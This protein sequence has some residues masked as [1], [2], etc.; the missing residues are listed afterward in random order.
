MLDRN[1]TAAGCF[2]QLN[3]VKAKE[4]WRK[5]SKEILTSVSAEILSRNIH[6][7]ELRM[8]CDIPSLQSRGG[9][10]IWN[11]GLKECVENGF[12][13][14][15]FPFSPPIGVDYSRP[16]SQKVGN[17]IVKEKNIANALEQEKAFY[18]HFQ[19]FASY[20]S[21]WGVTSPFYWDSS[22]QQW[23]FKGRNISQNLATSSDSLSIFRCVSKIL[24]VMLFL[25][26]EELGLM[27]IDDQ[28]KSIE[29]HF[30]TWRHIFT[31]TAGMMEVWLARNSITRTHFGIMLK[32][33]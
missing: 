10:S 27:S 19:E 7:R 11:D 26:L 6:N 4:S 16:R 15:H 31:N 28:V 3:N 14:I 5:Y 21:H 24:T 8:I 29:P 30:V 22:N 17:I 32:N 12:E 2:V 1:A 18:G 23:E 20:T 9:A 13:W 33:L 25:R